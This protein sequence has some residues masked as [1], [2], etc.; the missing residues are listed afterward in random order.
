MVMKLPDDE[1]IPIIIEIGDII[2]KHCRNCP[3]LRD[4]RSTNKYCLDCIH[5]KQLRTLGN[6]LI[7]DEDG[8]EMPP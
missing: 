5:F 6:Q 1:R 4:N 8:E 2:E 7:R 3:I